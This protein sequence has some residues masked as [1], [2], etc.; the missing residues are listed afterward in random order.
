MTDKKTQDPNE[1]MGSGDNEDSVNFNSEQ[2]S[3]SDASTAPADQLLI[4]DFDA[5][6]QGELD[7]IYERLDYLVSDIRKRKKKKMLTVYSRFAQQLFPGLSLVL[8]VFYLLGGNAFFGAYGMGQS[9]NL[10]LALLMITNAAILHKL[11]EI[12]D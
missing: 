1:D 6:L 2:V 5:M 10:G 3:D 8:G 4:E 7:G 12:E 9:V 11:F